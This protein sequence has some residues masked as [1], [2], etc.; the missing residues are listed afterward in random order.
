MAGPVLRKKKRIKDIES[1]KGNN[2][3]KV[4]EYTKL[5]IGIK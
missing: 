2:R 4:D 5:M 3:N 1:K